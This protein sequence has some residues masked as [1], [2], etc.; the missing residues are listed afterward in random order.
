MSGYPVLCDSE[1][2]I[3]VTHEMNRRMLAVGGALAVAIVVASTSVAWSKPVLPDGTTFSPDPA[4]TTGIA[5]PLGPQQISPVAAY[6]KRVTYTVDELGQ[7]QYVDTKLPAGRYLVEVL[8]PHASSPPD[9]LGV[10]F[11]LVPPHGT[12]TAFTGHVTVAKSGDP[13]SISCFE[14]ATTAQ[15]T[16]SYELTFIPTRG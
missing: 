6:F 15:S 4:S 3:E 1:T 11:P 16:A 2:S 5:G 9:C 12:A 14:Q 8:A 13:V 10:S 7:Y